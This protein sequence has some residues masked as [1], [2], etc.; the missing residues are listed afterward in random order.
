MTKGSFCV[1]ILRILMGWSEVSFLQLSA[2]QYQK[3]MRMRSRR[4]GLG[5]CLLK[6]EFL[7]WSPHAELILSHLLCSSCWDPS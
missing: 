6:M 1:S 7:V 2:V 3:K 5:K 4:G